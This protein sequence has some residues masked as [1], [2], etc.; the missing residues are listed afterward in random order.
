MVLPFKI[1][2]VAAMLRQTVVATIFVL[3][4][5]AAQI[6]ATQA[7]IIGDSPNT[8]LGAAVRASPGIFTRH[9]GPEGTSYDY[10]GERQYRE[11][12]KKIPDRKPQTRDPW[13]NIRQA[14]TTAP[15]DRH[16]PH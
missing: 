13:G 11:A 1:I 10:E 9:H 15:V 16:R 4:A 14:P 3:L 5:G 8:G 6:D 12:L 7:Q 2:R